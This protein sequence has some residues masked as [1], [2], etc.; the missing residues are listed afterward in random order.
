MKKN[1]DEEMYEKAVQRGRIS[2]SYLLVL[3]SSSYISIPS[4]IVRSEY[5]FD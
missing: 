4:L 3:L 1:N 5:C 2:T